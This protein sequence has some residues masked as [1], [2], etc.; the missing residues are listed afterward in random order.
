MII[1]QTM[2]PIYNTTTQQ[3]TKTQQTNNET[4]NI[5]TNIGINIFFLQ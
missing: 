4:N 5:I 1:K 2:N 3:I